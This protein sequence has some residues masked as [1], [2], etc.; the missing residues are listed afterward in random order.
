MGVSTVQFAACALDSMGGLASTARS[1]VLVLCFADGLVLLWAL[2]GGV[3]CVVAL[4]LNVGMGS[5]AVFAELGVV[6]EVMLL[7]RGGG[8]RA[9]YSRFVRALVVALLRLLFAGFCGAR[10]RFTSAAVLCG[11]ARLLAAFY[12]LL[13]CG[14]RSSAGCC[15]CV[16]FSF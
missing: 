10:P 3:F 11:Y 14:R 9:F 2:S 12:A 1:V 6:G 8:G 7:A 5:P 4:F 15:W 13:C 16:V